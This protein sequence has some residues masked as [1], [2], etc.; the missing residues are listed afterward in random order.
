MH[1]NQ[2][3]RLCKG[4]VVQLGFAIS[5]VPYAMLTNLVTLDYGGS[6]CTKL[7]PKS[8]QSYIIILVSYTTLHNI[9]FDNIEY[10]VINRI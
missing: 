8:S 4:E 10:N 3:S 7:S 9:I 1:S 5:I 2:A 6:H